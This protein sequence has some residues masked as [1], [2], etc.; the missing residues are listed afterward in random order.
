LASTNPASGSARA[1]LILAIFDND[2]HINRREL[3]ILLRYVGFQLIKCLW[4]TQGAMLCQRCLGLKTR[5]FT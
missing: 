4:R 3:E 5:T 2:A 1:K